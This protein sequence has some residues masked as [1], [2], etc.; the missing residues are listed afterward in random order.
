MATNRRFTGR[1][2]Q[3]LEGQLAEAI[4]VYGAAAA[5]G[6]RGQE[7]ALG[8]RCWPFQGLGE[9]EDEHW[10]GEGEEAV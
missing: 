5:R 2:S 3:S 10:A 1:K 4:R 7:A 6:N 9:G 8:V